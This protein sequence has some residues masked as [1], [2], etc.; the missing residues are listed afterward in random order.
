MKKK[1]VIIGTGGHAKS[2]ANV[3]NDIKK[4]QII[5]YV[6]KNKKENPGSKLKVICTE[7]NLIS[8]RKKKINIAI[9]GVG[10]I[11]SSKIRRNIFKKLKKYK[12]KTPVIISK[13]AN[14]SKNTK[15]GLGTCI[16]SNAF[17]N[18]D[19]KIGVNCIINTG[20]IIEHDVEIGNNCH[21]ST[22]VIINGGVKIGSDV[23][24]GSGSIISNNISIPKN[25]FIKMGSNIKK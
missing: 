13:S 6:G 2:L 4:F 9:I 14:V 10:Q 24:I 21:I 19:V 16:F 11:H 25:S 8:L 3:I 15:I 1:I 7:K 17:I 22:G 18:T 23:F 20:A 5:G 12:F